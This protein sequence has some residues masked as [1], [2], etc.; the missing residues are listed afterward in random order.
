MVNAK[1]K[2]YVNPIVE[3]VLDILWIKKESFRSEE[4]ELRIKEILSDSPEAKENKELALFLIWKFGWWYYMDLAPK[5]RED[6]DIMEAVLREDPRI[7]AKIPLKSRI[8]SRNIEATLEWYISEKMNF[9]EVERF[10][11]KQFPEAKDF[12]KYF[13]LYKKLFTKSENI[14]YSPLE[15]HLIDLRSEKPDFYKLIFQKELLSQNGRNISLHKKALDYILKEISKQE[16][17]YTRE[18]LEQKNTFFSFICVYLWVSHENLSDTQKYFLWELVQN[19]S[20]KSTQKKEDEDDESVS[21]VEDIIESDG[22]SDDEWEGIPALA[23]YSYSLSPSGHCYIDTASGVVDLSED[24]LQS[25]NDTALQNYLFAVEFLERVGLWFA[26]K[27]KQQLFRICDIDYKTDS[28]LTEWKLLRVCNRLWKKLGIPQKRFVSDEGESDQ[29]ISQDVGCFHTLSEAAYRFREI[30][31]S[32][33]VNNDWYYDP[34][35]R[36][37]RNIVEIYLIEKWDFDAE[38]RGF[39]LSK[40]LWNDSGS[41][42]HHPKVGTT[43]LD[44]DNE[45]SKIVDKAIGANDNNAKV[46]DDRD[47][48]LQAA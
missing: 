9:V 43:D 3:E 16:N 24:E 10:L 4:T 20:Q 47:D 34:A 28:W 33:S 22:F 45:V 15:R 41:Q 48:A 17:F 21:T 19:I 13:W 36:G 2:A 31:A 8:S 40:F 27:H 12:M 1:N 18:A 26:L 32:G 5:L 39:N 25:F 7:F 23:G 29:E 11:T 42:A 14:M 30:A 37:N 6:K 46:K 38:G 35:K 44:S